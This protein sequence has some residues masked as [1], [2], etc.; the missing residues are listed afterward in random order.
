MNRHEARPAEA[1]LRGLFVENRW[2]ISASSRTVEIGDPARGGVLERVAACNAQDVDLAVRSARQARQREWGEM[3]GAARAGCLSALAGLIRAE[4]RDIAGCEA[5]DTGKPLAQAQ[6]ETARAAQIFAGCAAALALERQEL[7]LPLSGG[8]YCTMARFPHGV[9]GHIIPWTAPLLLA[10]RTLAPALAMGNACVIKPSEQACLTVLRLAE[11]ARQAGFP[12]GALNVVTGRG[13]LAGAALSAHPGLDFLSFTGSPEVGMLVQVA[14][15]RNHLDCAIERGGKSP[16]IIFDDAD[17]DAALDA[18]IPAIIA[19]SGQSCHAGARVLV[20]AGHAAEFMSR[21]RPKFAALVAGLP[22]GGGDLGPV[23]SAMQKRRVERFCRQ[24]VADGVPVIATG[25]VADAAP[26][27][28]HFVTPMA[29]GPVPPDHPLARE[30]IFGPVLAVLTFTDEAEAIRL[31]HAVS[32]GPLV[33]LWT[34]DRDKMQRLRRA[35]PVTELL[36]NGCPDCPDWPD[37]PDWPDQGLRPG[38]W[39]GGG[40]DMITDQMML[41]RFS[42][43]SLLRWNDPAARAPADARPLAQ[44]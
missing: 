33:R 29:F 32:C 13:E 10:A 9:T 43:P 26:A 8:D 17:L 27:E 38:P 37:W 41:G 31:A 35:L 22:D 28:G 3:D 19:N 4:A 20:Q 30:D 15:A 16:Q 14:V 24:A 42:T 25:R 11:L 34:R 7:S 36:W 39:Q 1:A 44:G 18:V 40:V 21:L 6:Q 12:P 2:Q 23:I 5:A